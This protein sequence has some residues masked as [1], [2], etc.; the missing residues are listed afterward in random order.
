MDI[1]YLDGASFQVRAERL[2]AINPPNAAPADIVLHSKRQTRSKHIVNGPGEYEIGGVLIPTT[3]VGPKETPTL[4]HALDFDG[5]SVVHLGAAVPELD[6]RALDAL[7]RVDVLLLNADDLKAAQAAVRDLEPRVVIP[8]GQRA[9][10]LCAALG[11]K[12]R[13]AESRFSWNGVTNPPRA[14]LLKAPST[15]KRAA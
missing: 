8:F 3:E 7:G 2:I 13:R 1:T 9:A 4:V 15:R 14:V 11:V 10:E 5:M 6:D 12:E